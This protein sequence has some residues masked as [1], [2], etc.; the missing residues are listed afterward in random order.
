MSLSLAL[1][2]ISYRPAL[3]QVPSDLKEV[4][5][6]CPLSSSLPLTILMGT[7]VQLPIFCPERLGHW[8]RPIEL[9]MNIFSFENMSGKT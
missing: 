9:S 4:R 2:W 6:E 7:L 3:S 8:M 5:R 1:V